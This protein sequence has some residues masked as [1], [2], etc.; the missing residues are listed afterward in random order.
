M[1]TT[2]YVLVDPRKKNEYR[3][4]GKTQAK[5]ARRLSG[6]I[7]DAVKPANI[8]K[9]THRLHW[10]RKLIS[11]GVKPEI[12]L[13]EIVDSS[14]E[15]DQEIYWI[16]RLKKEGHK[17]TNSTKGGDGVEFTPEVRKK[18]SEAMSGTKHPNYGKRGPG[19]TMYGKTHSKELKEK[20][21]QRWTGEGNPKYGKGHLIQG[22]DNPFYGRKHT[23]ETKRKISQKMK[24]KS[25]PFSG[26]HHSE[27][28][29]RKLSEA[30]KL[31]IQKQ[32]NPMQGRHHTEE[33]KR[34][35]SHKRR[36]YLKNLKT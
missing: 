32:G 2:I 11:E 10:L 8:L 18:I 30:A 19:I 22:K 35:I 33:T 28:T 25:S 36:L 5:L 6:H 31:L 29:K 7:Y 4:V 21:S 34:K 15:N 17:L 26:K 23:E 9:H 27:E 1:K 3:Y 13:L 12:I 16:A 24:G 20:M 14:K